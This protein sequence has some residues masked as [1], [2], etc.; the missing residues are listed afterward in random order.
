MSPHYGFWHFRPH[1][2]LVAVKGGKSEIS[3]GGKK[4][5][6]DSCHLWICFFVEPPIRKLLWWKR[7][8]ETVF[9]WNKLITALSFNFIGKTRFITIAVLT[10]LSVWLR[11]HRL[12]F[13]PKRKALHKGKAWISSRECELPLN[14]YDFQVQP[15]LECYYLLRSYLKAKQIY[16]KIIHI[17]AQK[18]TLKKQLDKNVIMNIQWT[19]FP[20]RK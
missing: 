17:R 15:N 12:Y 13:L 7:S 20:M 1:T 19:Q 3:W 10:D 18:L 8:K 2:V 5:F 14:S 6:W 16:L 4:K 11:I 9:I